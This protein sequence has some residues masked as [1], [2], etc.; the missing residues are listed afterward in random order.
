MAHFQLDVRQPARSVLRIVERVEQLVEGNGEDF[1]L[2]RFVCSV[3]PLAACPQSFDA[4]VPNGDGLRPPVRDLEPRVHVLGD[5]LVRPAVR[6]GV[7]EGL[8]PSLPGAAGGLL[9]GRVA[10]A[11]ELRVVGRRRRGQGA[12]RLRATLGCWLVV[13]ELGAGGGI[14]F[15]RLLHAVADDALEIFIGR[16]RSLSVPL[17]RPRRTPPSSGATAPKV[18]PMPIRESAPLCLTRAFAGGRPKRLGADQSP[19]VWC[20]G[21]A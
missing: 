12:R 20:K 18:P 16:H 4:L 10:H 14:G 8:D 9:D 17:V 19:R 11:G 7:I 5:F 1:A 3:A 21:L 6:L 15:A 2:R 13:K